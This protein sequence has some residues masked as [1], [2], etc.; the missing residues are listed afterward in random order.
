MAYLV[1]VRHGTSTYNE[2]GLWTG[3]ADP[4]LNEQGIEEAKKA[5]ESL[6]DIHF[7]SAYSSALK[8]AEDTLRYI[9]EVLGQT[10]IPVTVTPALNERN[11]GDYTGKNKWEI[12]KEVGEEV[13]Q[14][15]RRSWDYQIP[16]G[17]SLK[18]VYGREIPYYTTEILPKLK[19]GQNVIIASSG[20]A[21]RAIVKHLEH[22]SDEAIAH[23]EIGLGE[24]YVYSFNEQGEITHKEIRS[25]NNKRGKI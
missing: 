4:M 18:Q 8:R 1:L 9:L 3:W 7:D 14:Q 11:Y 25:V 23:L 2:Q 17:E 12:Q 21:L 10:Q 15:I 16:H 19:Q 5:G 6:L 22:I 20:N 13:F 24:V